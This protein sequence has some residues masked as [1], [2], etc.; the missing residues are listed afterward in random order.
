MPF[1]FK[2]SCFLF[3]NFA[4]LQSKFS[5][6]LIYFCF[7]L[8]DSGTL[9]MGASIIPLIID[10]G[11]ASEQGCDAACI[12]FPWLL[13][14]GFSITFASLFTKTHRVNQIF[15][16]AASFKRVKI[17][18]LDVAKPMLVLIGA[19]ILV[20]SLWTAL[21]PPHYDTITVTEDQFDRPTETF[22]FC[23]SDSPVYLAILGAIN[24]G[25]LI[26][27]VYEAYSA[28]SIST[29]FSESEYIFKIL[30]L[31]LLVFFI[32]IPVL[33][34][35]RDNPAAYAFVFAG[36]IFTVCCSVLLLIFVPKY[37]ALKEAAKKSKE[38]QERKQER[39]EERKQAGL[40]SEVSST[41]RLSSAE[42]EAEG[43]K[44]CVADG[45]A[46]R[47]LEDENKRLRREVQ[48]YQGRKLSMGSS[49]PNLSVS[50][51]PSDV[52]ELDDKTRAI[53]NGDEEDQMPPKNHVVSFGYLKEDAVKEEPKQQQQQEDAADEEPEQSPI[54]SKSSDEQ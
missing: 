4:M 37:L 36:I 48:K 10:R 31:I 33:V 29:E 23:V 34:I 2:C 20:L 41:S 53:S 30:V 26:F 52:P 21:A 3:C 15:K 51:L 40:T 13:A 32:G 16:N 45:K 22:G 19:N 1:G 43:V 8:F 14:V 38:K 24:A 18:A 49:C 28:R 39:K 11:V 17:S 12:A 7:S 42:S 6:P 54:P 44:F 27:S 25:V 9:F 50:E 46:Q 5:T 47:E 35:A